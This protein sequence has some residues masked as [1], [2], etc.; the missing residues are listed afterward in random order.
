MIAQNAEKETLHNIKL[1]LYLLLS[2]LIA[3][4]VNDINTEQFE[5]RM[6]IFKQRKCKN[7]A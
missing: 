1:H 2:S 6:K 7:A 5:T 4:N 3:K